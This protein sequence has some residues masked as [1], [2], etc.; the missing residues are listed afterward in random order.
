MIL[1]PGVTT[2]RRSASPSKARPRSSLFS[3]VCSINAFK[4]SCAAGWHTPAASCYPDNS[5]WEEGTKSTEPALSVLSAEYG[6]RRIREV[7]KRFEALPISETEVRR[8][9]HE[10]QL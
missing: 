1:P 10:A 6:T 4:F 3:I 8:M 5:G 2:P 9:L 7:L